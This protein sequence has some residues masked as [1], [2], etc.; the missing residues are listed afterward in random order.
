MFG[1]LRPQPKVAVSTSQ[2]P[3]LIRSERRLRRKVQD[4]L[5]SNGVDCSEPHVDDPVEDVVRIFALYSGSLSK[6]AL[7]GYKARIRELLEANSYEVMKRR[8]LTAQLAA[9]EAELARL[10]AAVREIGRHLPAADPPAS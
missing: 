3:A 8:E 9:A 1:F 6:A 7:R 5:I 4:F 2:T 10:K